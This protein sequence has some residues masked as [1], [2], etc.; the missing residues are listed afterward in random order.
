MDFGRVYENKYPQLDIG[1]NYAAATKNES[2]ETREIAERRD[3]GFSK[4]A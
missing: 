4:G 2:P 3:R 1:G